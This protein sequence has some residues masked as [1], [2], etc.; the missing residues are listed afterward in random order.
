[1]SFFI[2]LFTLAL[3]ATDGLGLSQQ[4][5]A[6][7]QS[8]LAASMLVGRPICGLASDRYGSLNVS[9]LAT[10]IAGIACL[11]LW[12]PSRSL[13]VLLV[14][15]TVQGAVAGTTWSTAT[16]LAA[17]VGGHQHARATIAL[18]WTS[19]A[20]PAVAAQPIAIALA[21]FSRGSLGRE[22]AEVYQISIG[23]CGGLALSAGVLLLGVKRC[24]NQSIR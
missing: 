7:V 17:A 22:G 6:I 9:F 16:P 8:V 1:M 19:M 18:F 23:V 12:L 10:S 3:Y 5:G 11:S 2:S 24:M 13:A 20:I 21:Q 15:A 4:Q 14:F